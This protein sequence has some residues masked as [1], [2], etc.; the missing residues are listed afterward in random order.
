MTRFRLAL[1]LLLAAG[2]KTT[3]MPTP[4]S[5]YDGNVDPLAS[6]R[7]SER[8]TTT[9]VFIFTDRKPSGKGDPAKFYS[10]DRSRKGR[11]AA[12]TVDLAKD[13]AWGFPKDYPSIVKP[14]AVALEQKI[15][16]SK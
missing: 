9:Q 12:A 2:C 8:K 10:D 14:I 16:A 7:E 15:K 3:L 1:V 4:V 11:L 6:V 5:W 13:L